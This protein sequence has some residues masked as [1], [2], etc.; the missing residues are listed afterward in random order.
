MF[1][2]NEKGIYLEW[3]NDHK[4]SYS[5]ENGIGQGKNI[6]KIPKNLVIMGI[7]VK[8]NIFKRQQYCIE[9]GIPVENFQAPTTCQKNS[10]IPI[11]VEINLDYYSENIPEPGKAFYNR[12]Q[13]MWSKRSSI[14]NNTATTHL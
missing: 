6:S 10:A 3:E 11:D 7:N 14:F 8:L 2:D 12:R 1:T 5:E 4:I 13:S 9:K